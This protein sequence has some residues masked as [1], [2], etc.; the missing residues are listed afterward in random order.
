MT[1]ESAV[2]LRNSRF[3]ARAREQ[4][5]RGSRRLSGELDDV[6]GRDD[7]VAQNYLRANAGAPDEIALGMAA[8][9]AVA[10]RMTGA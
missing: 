2:A 5:G 6:G 9:D 4:R 10:W 8:G 3:A 1:E 7:S